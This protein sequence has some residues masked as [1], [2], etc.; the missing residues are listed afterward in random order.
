MPT[1]DYTLTV[2]QVK[3]RL[4]WNLARNLSVITEGGYNQVKRFVNLPL[5]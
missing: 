3:M 4:P 2:H 1:S 5:V